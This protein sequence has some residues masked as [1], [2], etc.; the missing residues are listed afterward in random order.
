MIGIRWNEA[1]LRTY[2]FAEDQGEL[3]SLRETPESLSSRG[4][5]GGNRFLKLNEPSM[6]GKTS[7][8]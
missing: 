1:E 7:G 2:T 5:D 6:R 3:A 8:H 4:K